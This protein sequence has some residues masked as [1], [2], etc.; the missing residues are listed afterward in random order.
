MDK[1]VYTPNYLQQRPLM[2]EKEVL[3]LE[4]AVE[5]HGYKEEKYINGALNIY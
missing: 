2:D 5:V 1:V 4:Q 3:K